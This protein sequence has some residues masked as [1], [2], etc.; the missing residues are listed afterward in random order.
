ML[1]F[2]FLSTLKLR[3]DN[4][5]LGDEERNTSTKLPTSPTE[6]WRLTSTDEMEN[7]I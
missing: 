7:A 1:L 2:T 6:H 4:D 3:T 5:I